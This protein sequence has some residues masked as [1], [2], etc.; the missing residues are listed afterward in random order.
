MV[1]LRNDG[2]MEGWYHNYL[3]NVRKKVIGNT[4][5]F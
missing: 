4:N 3:L 2:K 1:E 5:W